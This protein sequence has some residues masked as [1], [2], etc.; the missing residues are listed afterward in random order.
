MSTDRKKDR[1]LAEREEC[2]QIFAAEDAGDRWV[3]VIAV[4][5]SILFHAALLRVVFPNWSDGCEEMFRPDGSCVVLCV[6]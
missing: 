2:F 6:Q 5:A 3:A 1:E 4:G